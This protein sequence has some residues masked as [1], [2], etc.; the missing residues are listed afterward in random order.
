M[1][2]DY[3]NL[4]G[5]NQ[6]N[7]ASSNFEAAGTQII[8][9]ILND[10]RAVCGPKFSQP[11]NKGHVDCYTSIKISKKEVANKLANEVENMVSKDEQ[12]RIRLQE[13]D[14]RAKMEQRMKQ[15]N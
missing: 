1:I 5:N 9:A 12:A 10:T 3:A 4:I 7:D 15:A 6:G 2:D 13:S 14:F 8:N 11:D